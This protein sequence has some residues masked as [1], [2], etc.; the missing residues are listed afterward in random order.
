[1]KTEVKKIEVMKSDLPFPKL[2]S[3][4]EGSIVFFQEEKQGIVVFKSKNCYASWGVG[5]YFDDW[6]M[7]SFKDLSSD[8][9]VILQ[10]D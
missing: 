1:M 4:K 5:S 3:T 10:N 6:R 9:Q 8:Q 7:P 2:M